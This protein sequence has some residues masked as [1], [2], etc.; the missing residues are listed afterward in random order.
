MTQ[1]EGFSRN[2]AALACQ[3]ERFGRNLFEHPE[4]TLVYKWGRGGLYK[5]QCPS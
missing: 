4:K 3:H 5:P 2:N 1:I